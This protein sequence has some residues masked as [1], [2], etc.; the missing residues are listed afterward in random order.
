VRFK[1]DE[2]LDLRLVPLFE[3][4]G[5]DVASVHGEGLS[6][7]SDDLIHAACQ[8]E[9]RTLV[10]LDMDFSNPLR[11]PPRGTAGI[12]IVRPVRPILSQ[13]RAVLR[14]GLPDLKGRELAGR[15]WIVEPGRIRVYDPEER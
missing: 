2:N 1:L 13:I 8:R 3:E 12:V 9:E 6:G 10:S 11:F 4:G 5:H 7:Q 14:A 15:L